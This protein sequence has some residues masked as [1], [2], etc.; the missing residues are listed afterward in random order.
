MDDWPYFFF[1]LFLAFLQFGK[2]F[3]QLT[4]TFLDLSQRLRLRDLRESL[5]LLL[6]LQQGLLQLCLE[7]TQLLACCRRFY[8]GTKGAAM[9]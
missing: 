3:L 8:C 1:Q 6:D 5:L 4:F 9:N 7:H 2:L